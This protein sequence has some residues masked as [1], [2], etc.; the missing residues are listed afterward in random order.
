[1]GAPTPTEDKKREPVA[2][3]IAIVGGGITG[4]FC[5]YVLAYN[6]HPVELFESSDEFGGRIRSFLLRREQMEQC[7][8]DERDGTPHPIKD[9][10][11]I[12]ELEVKDGEYQ[13]LSSAP[14]SAPCASN[15]TFRCC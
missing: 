7:A 1:M 14:N 12:T 2:D 4:L 9:R 10:A 5:A 3:T 13:V 11:V 8:R 6:G 15:S